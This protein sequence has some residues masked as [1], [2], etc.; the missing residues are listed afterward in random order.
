MQTTPHPIKTIPGCPIICNPAGD[1][2]GYASDIT[3]SSDP[4]YFAPM[5]VALNQMSDDSSGGLSNDM[6][7]DT[8]LSLA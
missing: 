4:T 8:S 5:S 6:S 7:D 2:T 3:G 1:L